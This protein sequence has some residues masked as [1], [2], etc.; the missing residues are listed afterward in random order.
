MRDVAGADGLIRAFVRPPRSAPDALVAMV[1]ENEVR[2]DLSSYE[3]GRAAVLAVH[4]GAFPT[5]EAAVDAM[6]ATASKAKRS[7]V[8]SFALLHEELGDMLVFPHAL[9]E[10]QCL[11]LAGA[12]KAGQGGALRAALA[13]GL[14]TEPEREWAELLRALTG[15]EAAARTPRRTA[16]EP[17]KAREVKP[18]RG[19]IALANGRGLRHVHDAKGH[20]LRFEGPVDTILI[21][22]VMRQIEYLLEDVS[23]HKKQDPETGSIGPTETHRSASSPH[24]QRPG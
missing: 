18:K 21:D 10:R 9:S 8:R 14:G 5:L 16:G 17:G 3:R 19:Y 20:A 24:R 15:L 11:R 13:P 1:E 4:D 2:A 22:D 12:I 23:G 6:F 7:K